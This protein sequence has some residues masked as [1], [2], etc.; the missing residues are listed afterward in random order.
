MVL[1]GACKTNCL[2]HGDHV[3][4]EIK[5]VDITNIQVATRYIEKGMPGEELTTLRATQLTTSDIHHAKFLFCFHKM[6]SI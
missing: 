1:F 4:C 6:S 2:V 3:T 5:C